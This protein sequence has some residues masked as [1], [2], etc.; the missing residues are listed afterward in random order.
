[1]PHRS[2]I[3]AKIAA[4]RAKTTGAGCTE[5]EALAAAELAAQLMREHG[6][7]DADVEMSSASAPERTTR[8]TWRTP[9]AATVATV[10][11][12]AAILLVGRAEIEFIGRDPGPEI[13]V[14]LYTVLVRAVERAARG[15]KEGPI[16]RRRRTT[17]TRRAALHDFAA[18]MVQRLRSRLF[19]LFRGL[20]D[21]AS[22]EAA[23][24][25]LTTRYGDTRGLSAPTKK[26]RF[27]DAAVVGWRA[28]GDVTLAHGVA[29]ADGRP[30]AIGGA[31]G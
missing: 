31:H 26:V 5:A 1:M 17:K 21:K 22:A 30:L 19:D 28:G 9:L 24:C 6:L 13:A 11:N 10:T 16:Y 15:F 27:A 4:L 29:G 20:C 8:S 18:S 3:A 25:A 14:Y 7:S 2:K 23:L 12:T